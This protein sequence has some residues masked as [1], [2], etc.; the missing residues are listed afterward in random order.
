MIGIFRFTLF[1]F[2]R[3]LSYYAF[4]GPFCCSRSPSLFFIWETIN[5]D[6]NNDSSTCASWTQIWIYLVSFKLQVVEHCKKV[7]LALKLIGSS[8]RNKPRQIWEREVRKWSKGTS[9]LSTEGELLSC[10]QSSINV[11]GQQDAI[12]KECFMD[13]GSF[14]EDKRIHPGILID[15][16]T[17]LY[18]LE[19]NDV[20][21]YLFD[22]TY[23][24]LVNFDVKRYAYVGWSGSGSYYEFLIICVAI[25]I[26][27]PH[28][29]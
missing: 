19:D 26:F 14:P 8:L 28:L 17:E 11:L 1:L 22:L 21:A 20:I 18:E 27:L 25:F 13:L 16:W 12:L 3:M 29:I 15:L 23:H 2:S 10:L 9:I 5:M 6:L 24:N 7:P 4:K